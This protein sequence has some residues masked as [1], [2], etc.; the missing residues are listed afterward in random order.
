MVSDSI[1]EQ[2]LYDVC[3]HSLAQKLFSVV[4]MQSVDIAVSAEFK[5]IVG[6]LGSWSLKVIM[7]PM[8]YMTINP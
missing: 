4:C 6:I 2:C 8:L 5:T 7:Q 3:H 1:C